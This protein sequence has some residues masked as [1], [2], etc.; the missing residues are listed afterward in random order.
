MGAGV[1]EGVWEEMGKEP[2]GK[3]QTNGIPHFWLTAFKNVNIRGRMIQE[4]G[5]LVLEHLKDVKIKFS[6]VEEPMS[7]SVEFVFKSNEYF[8]NKV[9]TKTCR[10]RSDPDDSDPFFSKGLGTISSTGSEIYWIEGENATEKT[11]KL[12]LLENYQAAEM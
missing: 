11:N 8:S 5:E 7:F 2:E 4:N 12:S 1:Q 10:R 3:G 6:R 9:L